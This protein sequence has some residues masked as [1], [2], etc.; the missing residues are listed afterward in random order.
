MILAG[1]L[2]GSAGIFAKQIYASDS[3]ITPTTISLIGA[4]VT[5]LTLLLF[6]LALKGFSALRVSLDAIPL[7]LLTGF[8]GIALLN[9]LYFSA[10]SSTTVANA[11]LLLYSAPAFVTPL[12]RFILKEHVGSFKLGAVAMAVLGVAIVVGFFKGEGV[13]TSKTLWGDTLALLA[14]L[15]YATFFVVTRVQVRRLDQFTMMFYSTFFGA[16]FLF[17]F[18]R[19]RAEAPISVF[20]DAWPPLIGLS[21]F[22]MGLPFILFAA[23]I[24]LVKAVRASIS[25]VVEPL[26][27]IILAA[28]FL[29]QEANLET[30]LGGGLIIGS[31]LLSSRAERSSGLL[32]I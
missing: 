22:A 1:S 7:L 19:V 11:A 27:A 4:T 20:S 8:S 9:I 12:S 30:A 15:I 2:W 17:L 5:A 24:K 32:R 13:F 14:G 31:I 25:G 21:I 3:S 28:I 23:S 29:Q 26:V 6:L 18:S 10:L 16:L